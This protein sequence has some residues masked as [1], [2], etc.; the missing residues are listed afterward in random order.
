[1][2]LSVSSV[3]PP[4]VFNCTPDRLLPAVRQ[5]LEGLLRVS[6]EGGLGLGAALWSLSSYHLVFVRLF[7]A[8]GWRWRSASRPTCVPAC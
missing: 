7:A 1:M 8:C 2:R 5:E 6:G 3:A 4:Q